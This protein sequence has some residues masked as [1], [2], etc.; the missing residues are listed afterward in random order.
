MDFVPFVIL[1][2]M[3]TKLI[4][5]ILELIPDRFEPKILL[6]ISWAVGAAVVLLFSLSP[7]LAGEVTVWGDHNLSTASIGL[8][9]VYGFAVGTGSNV[10][11]D[12]T[13][14]RANSTG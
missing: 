11:H 5:W 13:S 14:R 1:S 8:V 12:A 3:V 9:L 10:V 2:L 6:P 4:D 7:E